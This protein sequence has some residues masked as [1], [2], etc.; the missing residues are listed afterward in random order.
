MPQRP[1]LRHGF[2]ILIAVKE[3]LGLSYHAVGTAQ[4][5]EHVIERHDLRHGVRGPCLLAVPKGGIRNMNIPSQQIRRIEV[6]HDEMKKQKLDIRHQIEKLQL[7]KQ[8]MMKN[9]QV[10][11]TALFKLVDEMHALKLQKKK[12]WLEF[13]LNMRKEMTPAQFEKVRELH[14]KMKG[15]H[16]KKG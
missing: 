7:E 6:L 1:A 15:K 16:R 13:K 12:K 4:L 14:A 10:D 8:T 3:E 2:L 5:C 11:K 9:Y